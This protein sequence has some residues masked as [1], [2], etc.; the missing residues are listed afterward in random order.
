MQHFFKFTTAPLHRFHRDEH[1]VMSIITLLTVLFLA[2]MLAMMLNVCLQADG[3]IRMQNSA[4]AATYSSGVIMARG[5]N[6]LAFTNHLLCDVF[7]LTAFLREG[8]NNDAAQLAQE[9]LNAW[10]STAPEFA[11]A[12]AWSETSPWR[13]EYSHV[14]HV[15]ETNFDNP[16]L[17]AAIAEMVPIQRQMVA[18]FSEWALA[19][20]SEVLPTLEKILEQ[21][22]IPEY[23]R[24]LT[25]TIG[26]MVQQSALEMSMRHGGN[27][28]RHRGEMGAAVWRTDASLFRSA[29]SA[30]YTPPVGLPVVDA[31]TDQGRGFYYQVA[32]RQRKQLAET[33]LNQWNNEKLEQFDGI[34]LMSQFANL[35]RGFAKGELRDLL[36]EHQETNLLHVIWTPPEMHL[37]QSDGPGVKINF[38]SAD[39]RPTISFAWDS[40]KRNAFLR[41]QYMFIGTVYWQPRPP[42]LPNLFT[43]PL[44]GD[45]VNFAQGMLHL[46][47]PRLAMGYSECCETVEPTHFGEAPYSRTRVTHGGNDYGRN[48]YG[49]SWNLLNQ[50]WQFKLVPA[51]HGVARVLAQPE[52][53]WSDESGGNGKPYEPPHLGELSD[54][55][56]GMINMH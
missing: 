41:Q 34:G 50:N 5:M 29:A 1:G 31:S 43:N 35:W 23:Q 54:A 56:I 24:A 28:N 15:N 38:R 37:T 40:N 32:L 33:Y 14:P 44:A 18:H 9:I 49:I 7:A 10:E 8:Q 2:F 3:K 30:R 13:G 53:Q 46:P 4:D 11:D 20:S 47:V 52:G 55:D 45:R 39:I 48:N 6:S 25:A 16:A 42:F 51:Y 21:Q 19:F 26:D 17:D 27:T 12:D 36:A 22:L